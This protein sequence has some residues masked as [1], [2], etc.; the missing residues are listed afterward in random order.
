MRAFLLLLLICMMAVETE[1]VG[2]FL[3]GSK[4]LAIERE[5]LNIDFRPLLNKEPRAR[6]EVIYKMVN[7]GTSLEQQ[8]FLAAQDA[9]VEFD[10]LPVTVRPAPLELPID[11]RPPD[12]TPALAHQPPIYYSPA[13][14]R[15]GLS[16]TLAVPTG[17][18]LLRL[19]Y[20]APAQAQSFSSPSL[21]WQFGYVLAPG[22]EWASHG[23]LDLYIYL[24]PN[25]EGACNLP[26]QRGKDMLVGSWN[27]LPKDNIAL[28]LRQI[29]PQLLHYSYAAIASG[30]LLSIF[31]TRLLGHLGYLQGRAKLVLSLALVSSL[32]TTIFTT[33][34]ILDLKALEYTLGTQLSNAYN[35]HLYSAIT[36]AALCALSLCS[37]TVR[38]MRKN[39]KSSSNT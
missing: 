27:S 28:T 35:S 5:T 3:G 25:W 30:L 39:I 22:K 18:H 14:V 21:F 24:P 11:F 31:G 17:Q 1:A 6:I 34:Y 12:T 8:F 23:G 37:A 19:L 26:V 7:S 9:V 15:D 38:S 16:F 32:S 13:V 2:E 29:P 10:G 4:R 33:S 20:S 36:A